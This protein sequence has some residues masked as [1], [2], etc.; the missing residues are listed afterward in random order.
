M[1]VMGYLDSTLSESYSATLLNS[2]EGEAETEEFNGVIVI[3]IT[4]TVLLR[5]SLE[6][7]KEY[8]GY[9]KDA[10]YL[11]IGNQITELWKKW[12]V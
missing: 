9:S 2:V 7:P 6:K 11:M 3:L 10:G 5:V 8:N 1:L 4:D 12:D